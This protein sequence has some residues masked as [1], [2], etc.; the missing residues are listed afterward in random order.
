MCLSSPPWNQSLAAPLKLSRS[1]F[2]I[3]S[4][5]TISDYSTEPLRKLIKIKGWQLLGILKSD[6]GHE[7]KLCYGLWGRGRSDTRT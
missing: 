5:S 3:H 6:F 7:E 1:L 2:S 4:R